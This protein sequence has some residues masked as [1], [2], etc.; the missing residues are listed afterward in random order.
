[1]ALWEDT[2]VLKEHATSI[3]MAKVC[4]FIN[5]MVI[6]GNY[7]VAVMRPKERE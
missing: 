4:R 7:K 1:M 2:T 5:R 3:F 6:Y